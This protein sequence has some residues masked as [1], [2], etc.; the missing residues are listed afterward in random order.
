MRNKSRFVFVSIFASL[1]FL[2]ASSQAWA[3]SSKIAR[4]STSAELA[5]GKTEG[6]VIDSDGIVQLGRAAKT[7]VEKFEDVWSINS[8]VVNGA[9]I[10][11]GTSPNGG[12][13]K[14]SMDKLTKIYPVQ[15]DEPAVEVMDANEPDD[16]NSDD[17]NVIDV[18]KFLS[19]EHIFAM[20]SD[21]TGRLLVG[22]SGDSCK[23][24]RLE[25]DEMKT[26]FEPN[27]ND[28]KYIFAI[29]VGEDGDIYLGTGPNG[30]IYK[31]D[32]FGKNQEVVYDST[33][34]NILCLAGGKDGF[35]YAG[36][37][38]RGLIYK[39]NPKDKT[40]TVLYDSGQP[41]I[42][43]LLVA[44]NGELFAAG[45]SAKIVAAQTEFAVKLSL[46]GRVE[47]ESTKPESKGGLK[48]NIANT[49]KTS[50]DKAQAR[51]PMAAAPAKPGQASFIY[52]I[53]AE[54][55]VTDVFARPAVL[56][57][58]AQRQDELLVGTGNSGELFAIDPTQQQN[59][60][61][62]KDHQASQITAVVVAGDNVYLG[63]SNPAKLIKLDNTFEAEGQYSSDLI[64]AGQ[65]AKWGKLQ[66]EADIPDAT[67]VSV[68]SRSGNVKD[69]NDSTF[70]TWTEPIEVTGPV[71]LRC[72]AGRFCQYKLFLKTSDKMVTPTIRE[73]AVASTVPNLAPRVEAVVVGRETADEKKGFFKIS[74]KAQDDNSDELIYKIDFRK[75]GR[76]S[77]IEI[78]D[79]VD[80]PIFEWDGRTV[81]DGR[82]EIRVTAD[83]SKSN[84][85]ETKLTGSR[86]SDPV[87]VD[88][89]GPGVTDSSMEKKS[90]KV[91][92]KLK[93]QDQLSIVGK[94][95]YSVDSNEKWQSTVPEDL[96]YDSTME[97]FVIVTEELKVGDHVI[98]IKASDDVGNVTY[99][100]FEITID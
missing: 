84:S 86:I 74:Y 3:V 77:W 61:V 75:T 83:D 19:N 72:P 78:K 8:I 28:A 49:K 81:E 30:K 9:T 93:V 92:L 97:N 32:S 38:G 35:I 36:S 76:T 23:L 13:Y 15:I 7:M 11:I 43:A 91:T 16:P 82:Y 2:A 80:K 6:T 87:V 62:Y 53:T 57:S 37:D 44:E 67:S 12:V 94:V 47:V 45:T 10:Y 65:P 34:N 99:K 100:T 55:F 33:D 88:N 96:I 95:E 56:F 26:V 85:P 1:F 4:Q 73:I 48:L 60:M 71:Q 42:T 64:D 5:K 21:I 90:S 79:D 63:T 68:A 24:M 51:P 89:T 31:L 50:S 18:E 40:A 20:A 25:N 14:Y 29:N 98:T 17:A 58:L 52:K 41:E 22:I 46:A 27:E 59:K 69:V 54:G 70:S 66:I 39:I